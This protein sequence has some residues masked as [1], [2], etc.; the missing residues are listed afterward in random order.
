VKF[1]TGGEACAG[2]ARELE[3]RSLM[4]GLLVDQDFAVLT[5]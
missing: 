2:Q 5:N 3:E 1:P 4:D